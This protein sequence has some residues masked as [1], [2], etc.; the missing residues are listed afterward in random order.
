MKKICQASVALSQRTKTGHFDTGWVCCSASIAAPLLDAAAQTASRML[1][2]FVETLPN[3]QVRVNSTFGI[4]ARLLGA[5]L[6]APSTE[7]LPVSPS[8]MSV[9]AGGVGRWSQAATKPRAAG[10]GSAFSRPATP[11]EMPSTGSGPRSVPLVGRHGNSLGPR[12]RYSGR[13]PP[14]TG[15]RAAEG[16]GKPYRPMGRR[17]K[18]TPGWRR[19][20]GWCRWAGRRRR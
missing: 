10:V 6:F 12:Y 14:R 9:P 2:W 4:G 16:I 13:R 19:A 15:I 11:V 18:P 7:S 1:S 20:G 8:R 5:H 17:L 3:G